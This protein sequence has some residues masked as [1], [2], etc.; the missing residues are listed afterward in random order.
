[1]L[2]NSYAFIFGFLPVTFAG[3]FWLAR[4]SHRLAALWL[5]I[6]SLVFYAAWDPRF[7]T[8]LLGSIAFNYS[9]G[10]WIGMRLSA[11]RGRERAPLVV[12]IV[13]NLAL[14]GYFKYANFFLASAGHLLGWRLPALDIVLPLGISFF[15]FTQIAF[16]VDVHRGL[17]RE[18][19]FVHY[20]LFVTYFPH[21]IAGPVLHH[22]QMMP[23]F[24]SPKSY[25]VSPEHLAVGFSIFVLGL[26]KKVLLADSLA[27]Y[28]TPIF[29]TARDGQAVM[30]FEA[31][32]GALAYTLQLYFDFSGYS[33]MAVGLSLLFNVRLPLN[34]DSP[35]RATSIIDFWRR[36]HMTLSTFLRD[37]L[38]IP[39]GGNRKGT[40][41][42]YAN[43]MATMLL[44]GLWH[45]A[46]WTFILWG[47]LHG[48]Y[49]A[50]NNLWRALKGRLGWGEDGALSRL[51]GGALTFL[52]VVVAWVFFRAESFAAARTI[53]AG[54]AGRSGVAL[55]GSLEQPLRPLL[56][57][58]PGVPVRYMGVLAGTKFVTAVLEIAA[59]LA[60]VWLLPNTRQ[61]FLRYRP[62]WED[63]A[64]T[65][66]S[67]HP[68]TGAPPPA[69][70]WRPATV[71]AVLVGV[72]FFVCL[73]TLVSTKTSEFL[74]FQF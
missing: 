24:A 4:H 27:A 21:L 5:G 54:M 55:P 40:V 28:A 67:G 29:A 48:V 23:Q 41:R 49:L 52:A 61:V 68:G 12:A 30:L 56:A 58:F 44:G 43:L 50:V 16:L 45:G 36:W 69:F 1:M 65:A 51:A 8:L 11:G 26:A 53:L 3:M 25:R 17:A 59:G 42:R 18:Y 6:A 32:I 13:A 47:G 34:F 15:T 39:L 70:R 9:A 71:P 62:T 37:Y 14:L 63:Y 2:F 66:K 57:L 72:L 7:V 33:D 31:W 19:N 73:L 22:K 20:L 35:Y 38:Y 74:Y 10:Y 64:R 60:I 46:G